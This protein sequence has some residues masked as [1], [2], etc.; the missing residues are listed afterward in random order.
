MDQ[1]ALGQQVPLNRARRL[2]QYRDTLSSHAQLVLSVLSSTLVLAAMAVLRD[3]YLHSNYRYLLIIIALSQMTI[4]NWRGVYRR[5]NGLTSGS[6]RIGRSWLLLVILAITAM[7]LSQSS[8]SFSRTVILGWAIIGYASQVAIYYVFSILSSR[9][10]LHANPARNS[11][12]IG[13]GLLAKELIDS[14]NRNSWIN[15]RVIGCVHDDIGPRGISP[16]N[17]LG[18]PHLGKTRNISNL[19][20]THQIS[21]VYIAVSIGQSR[22]IERIYRMLSSSTVDIVWVPDIFSMQLINHSIKELNGLPL[23]TLS[24]SPLASET[25]AL[26]KGIFDKTI[27]L[28]ML[29]ILS[30]LMLAVTFLVWQSSPGPIIFRQKRHG[31]D[32][33][34]IEVWKFR[35]M[36][37][38]EDKRVSQARRNDNRVTRIG[39]FIRRTSIDELPQLFNVLQGTMSLIGP[40][41]HAVEHNELY[42]KQIKFYML[43]HRVKPGIT[44]LAQVSGYRGETETLE[45]MLKRVEFDIHYINNWSLLMDVKILLKT[46]F[47]LLSKDIY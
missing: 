18:I 29:I 16:E 37:I 28:L 46:P 31:W 43:R 3:G 4:Y 40:R 8:N 2:L 38:H 15:D 33:R 45:K 24:E 13:G 17:L 41:P 1:L 12:V 22:D 30:P 6:L 47:S 14:I 11:M 36:K 34:V 32:G 20:A 35:S 9:S 5:F 26:L 42:S 39:K 25:R 19:I 10:K 23:I 7:F 44:G 21:K 27:A